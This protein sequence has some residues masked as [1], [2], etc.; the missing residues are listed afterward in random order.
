MLMKQF[1]IKAKLI[2]LCKEKALAPAKASPCKQGSPTVLEEG[3]RKQPLSTLKILGMRS[4]SEQHSQAQVNPC[5]T[6]MA[7]LQ[8]LH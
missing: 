1:G 3:T 2:V 7:V 4:S 5:R 6:W 8:T